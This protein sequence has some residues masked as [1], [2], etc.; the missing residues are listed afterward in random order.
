MDD[1]VFLL[2]WGYHTDVRDCFECGIDE[3]T[4][5]RRW[6]KADIRAIDNLDVGETYWDPDSD[7]R[8]LPKKQRSLVRVKRLE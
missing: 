8:Y 2:M 6:T 3:F 4:E 1:R 5:A 7:L